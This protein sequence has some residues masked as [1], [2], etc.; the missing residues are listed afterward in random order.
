[1]NNKEA[2]T[3]SIDSKALDKI[4]Q[5]ATANYRSINKHIQFIIDNY[6]KESTGIK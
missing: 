1:M 4:R 6:L 2:I 5:Q 3:I